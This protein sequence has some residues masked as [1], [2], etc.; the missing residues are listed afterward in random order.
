MWN[1]NS[2]FSYYGT[3]EY[4]YQQP[5]QMQFRTSNEEPLNWE[6]VKSLD[7]NLLK[8]TGDLSILQPFISDFIVADFEGCPS[9]L[10]SH[11]LLVRLC[12]ILQH[13]LLYMS[14]VQKQLQKKIELRDREYKEQTEKLKKVYNSYKKADKL[15]KKRSQNFEKCPICRKKY[16]DMRYLDNHFAKHHPVYNN[17]WLEIRSL[18]VQEP[19]NVV[20]DNSKEYSQLLELY[21]DLKQELEQ[22]RKERSQLAEEA[23][24][25]K[26]KKVN[27]KE[28]KKKHRS[29]SRSKLNSTE[30]II[31]DSSDDELAITAHDDLANS[32]SM[33]VDDLTK[34]WKSW[35]IQQQNNPSPV[36]QK[37]QQKIKMDKPPP[38]SKEQNAQLWAMRPPTPIPEMLRPIQTKQSP[39]KAAAQ[40]RAKSAMSGLSMN[41][42]GD[43]PN[44]FSN[45]N[46][47]DNDNFVIR[48]PIK[49]PSLIRKPASPKVDDDDSSLVLP[50]KDSV[51]KRSPIKKSP[52]R[53]RKNNDDSDLANTT[54]IKELERQI[55][56]ESQRT[57]MSNIER[58]KKEKKRTH[59]PLADKVIVPKKPSSK[60]EPVFI[61][62]VQNNQRMPIAKVL[63]KKTVVED[64]FEEDSDETEN[65]F[66]NRPVGK[67]EEKKIPPLQYD[68]EE[69]EEEI[70]KRTINN[71]IEK[72]DG[73]KIPPLI[74]EEEE[75]EEEEATEKKTIN[76]PIG[77]K[78]EK[79]IPPLQYD[80]EE[81]EEEEKRTI[82]RPIGKKEEKKIP[83][84]HIEEEEE[85]EDVIEKRVIN[86]PVGKKDAKKIP[87]LVFEEEEDYYNEESV[88]QNDQVN[89]NDSSAKASIPEYEHQEEEDAK[90]KTHNN[91]T[92]PFE[93][94]SDDS[95]NDE[96]P[97]QIRNEAQKNEDE[98][99]EEVCEKTKST[100]MS[101]HKETDDSDSLDE[102]KD[103]SQSKG[104]TRLNK[105]KVP[106]FIDS[107]DDFI[108]ST[109]KP[110]KE[111]SFES[112]S[113]F[114]RNAKKTKKQDPPK[115]IFEEEEEEEEIAK[116][117]PEKL[118]SFCNDS[119][120]ESEE[121]VVPKHEEESSNSEEFSDEKRA[122]EEKKK[123]EKKLLVSKARKVLKETV[124]IDE[125][126]V[127]DE[128]HIN[129][130]T[131]A[132]MQAVSQTFAEI[133]EENIDD[134]DKVRNIL[135]SKYTGDSKE[136][137][138]IK[139]K[140]RKQLVSQH[141]LEESESLESPFDMSL[142]HNNSLA[143]DRQS[144]LEETDDQIP[145]PNFPVTEEVVD[146]SHDPFE[147]TESSKSE[148]KKPKETTFGF[149]LEST[150]SSFVDPDAI[151]VTTKSNKPVAETKQVHDQP[152]VISRQMPKVEEKK[153][154]VEEE[155][156]EE[157]EYV[158]Y[159]YY[160]D[161]EDE[162][163]PTDKS[164]SKNSKQ[165]DPL[166]PTQL[167]ST[168]VETKI[169]EKAKDSLP[170]KDD[171]PK[172]VPIPEKAKEQSPKKNNLSPKKR[173]SP[174]KEASP[175]K[176]KES[177][178]IKEPESVEYFY[179]EEEIYV[180]EEEES[181]AR[182]TKS[183][184]DSK[185]EK[186]LK[187]SMTKPTPTFVEGT[188][189]ED[190]EINFDLT[191]TLKS[192]GTQQLSRTAT[193]DSFLSTEDFI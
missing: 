121:I 37:Q 97:E 87:P 119:D 53:I 64:E 15:L 125:D 114:S 7:P 162:K 45:R 67:K 28:K 14:N 9:R 38:V 75:E 94:N 157:E 169:V 74:I 176:E 40:T 1:P 16:K 131:A 65:I 68:E 23:S 156:M 111:P 66:T 24:K 17:A 107:D 177:S 99:E 152:R 165:A 73:R 189:T 120:E 154:V 190:G 83:S 30:T 117:V 135:K 143:N 95:Y 164:Q 80:D 5:P 188:S 35:E 122:R 25:L 172:P 21:N 70:E 163:K 116:P 100:V 49:E 52:R 102:T 170:Q 184:V 82:N 105:Q 153:V 136:Y 48:S 150:Q 140:I 33:A 192:T 11:P 161:D 109:K 129:R 54:E 144:F 98:E 133:P 10:L 101:D 103:E 191:D 85:E 138:K 180:D 178:K 106:V 46:K 69:E 29:R 115:P 149:S 77:K 2:N 174:K 132:L 141:P 20:Q 146:E 47:N 181:A 167:S 126:V 185:L 8:K 128:D 123:A 27:E 113:S 145:K 108:V 148:S 26:E 93:F 79:E 86:Q 118:V 62:P 44:P 34:S 127:K 50:S 90:D 168:K 39:A 193:K 31:E 175:K 61:K 171:I 166:I 57:L 6:L 12:M 32:L 22:E 42:I 142:I 110:I 179:E 3:P 147:V 159:Y 104:K 4:G 72:K 43:E 13:S 139:S 182:P 155:D 124:P 71:P 137:D 89:G 88:T 41:I 19:V 36:A 186:E 92:F 173:D 60:A 56:F 63:P 18:K 59:K 151:V 158:E 58:L 130:V 112:E 96:V 183:R 134:L 160:S 84:L 187:R 81:E 55:S 91:T 78:K 51:T 76:Q